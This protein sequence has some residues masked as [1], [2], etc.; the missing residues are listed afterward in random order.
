MNLKK[1]I[2]LICCVA[3]LASVGLGA[4]TNRNTKTSLSLNLETE[5]EVYLLGENVGI[6]FTLTNLG[7]SDVPVR[8]F[9]VSTGELRLFISNDGKEFKEYN[10]S[11]WGTVDAECKNVMKPGGSLETGTINILWN[12]SPSVGHLAEDSARAVQKERYFLRMLLMKK[13]HIF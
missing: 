6:K 10:D 8:C 11:G 5:K 4:I 1:I 7:R 13:E 12:Y 9:G 2:S 3:L